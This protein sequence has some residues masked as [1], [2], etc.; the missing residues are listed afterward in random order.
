MQDDDELKPLA[1]EYLRKHPE[2]LARV[3]RRR[4]L[5]RGHSAVRRAVAGIE[6]RIL[7]EFEQ[8]GRE[9]ENI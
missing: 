1:R 3:R 6:D 4:A 8:D 5:Q 9:P 2:V 7:C